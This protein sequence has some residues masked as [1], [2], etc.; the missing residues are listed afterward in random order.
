MKS[1][2]KEEG[3]EREEGTGKGT[4]RDKDRRDLSNMQV[5]TRNKYG[6]RFTR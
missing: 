4:G 1:K 2:Q 6:Q 5:E 3:G